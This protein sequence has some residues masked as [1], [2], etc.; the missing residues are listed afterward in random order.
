MTVMATTS[1]LFVLAT[2]LMMM[3]AYQTQTTS[4]RTAR[5]RATHVADAG[6]NAYLYQIRQRYDYYTVVP[7]TGVV[8][9]GDGETYRVRAQGPADGKPLTLY[10]TGNAGDGTVTIAATVRCPS[11]AD[12]MFCSDDSLLIG[13]GATINGQVHSNHDINNAGHITGKVT[14]AGTITNTGVLDQV[15]ADHQA[16]V[17]FTQVAID[18][19]SIMVSAQDNGAY[20]GPSLKLGYLV[21]VNGSSVTVDKVTG[22]NTTGNLTTTPV[23]TLT[24]PASGALYFADT[25]WVKGSYSVPLTIVSNSNIYVPNSYTPSD[26]GS[27]VTGGLIARQSII[28]PAWY[29]SVPQQMRLTAALLSQSGSI[30]ADMKYGVYRDN[31][32]INGS[33]TYFARGGFALVDGSGNVVGGFHTRVYSYDQRLDDYAP[34][35][36]PVIQDGALNVATWI[37]SK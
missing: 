16:P 8:T 33:E 2:T 11:F 1:I 28:V 26:M 14:A 37:E 15:P 23:R 32:T 4:V 17:S 24:V 22:G 13:A 29:P 36:Y 6:I 25:I 30:T 21:T 31:I 20:F 19:D 12:Y 10:S 3:V 9:I 18:M 27:T 35:K 34:P 7:D 5:V